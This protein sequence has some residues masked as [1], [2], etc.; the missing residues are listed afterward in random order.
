MNGND[1]AATA[2]RGGEELGA[3]SDGVS[4]AS[5]KMQIRKLKREITAL[6]SAMELA[7]SVSRT[8]A[9]FYSI[10]QAEKAR[11][12]QYLNM[13]LKNSLSIILL[14]N[15]EGRL[16]YCTDE[17]L[18]VAKIS[19]F[20][21][22]KG[23]L[24]SDIAAMNFGNAVSLA[25]V[26]KMFEEACH[27]MEVVHAEIA[28]PSEGRFAVYSVCITPMAGRDNYIGGFILLLHDVTDLAKAKERAELAS[29]AKSLFLARMSHEIRTPMNAIIGLGE[30]AYRECGQSKVLEHI[31]D[32]KN[33]G[34]NLLAIINDILDFS[35]IESG[36]ME[37]TLFP[38]E[39]SSLLSDVLAVIHIRMLEKPLKLITEISPTIPAVMTGDI[40]H[41]RQILFNLLGNAVKFTNQGFIKFLAYGNALTED[42]ILLTFVITDSGIGIR[43]EDVSRLFDDFIR[44]DEK[45]TSG[46]EGTGLGLTIAR[47]L[48]RA[49]G[50][51][52]DVTSEYGLGTTFTAT[53][54]QSVADWTPMGKIGVTNRRIET[55][56]AAF[57]APGAR[58]LVVDDFPSNL[59]VAEGLLALYRIKADTCLG[60]EEAI[61]RVG[62]R[63]YDLVF[64]DHMMPGM[65]GIET[66][67]AI[68][69]LG[70]RFTS[71]PIIALT[72]NAVSGM[73][74]MF[75]ENGFS[76]FL[77]KPIEM[78]KLDRML[79]KWVATE[80]CEEAPLGDESEVLSADVGAFP[81]IMGVDTADGISRIGGS[82]NRYLNL[83][84][85]FRRDA[86][87][88]FSLL[89]IPPDKA[90]LRVFTTL[91][92]SLK[93]AL[94]AIGAHALSQSAAL[95][96]K[97]CRKSEFSTIQEKL[98]P[99]RTEIHALASRIDE[100]LLRTH[101]G[102]EASGS[103]LETELLLLLKGALAEKSIDAMD[104]ALAKL[105]ALPLPGK[106]RKD[107]SRIAD[108]I[109]TADFEIAS[110]AVAELLRRGKHPPDVEASAPDP[111]R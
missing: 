108:L 75:L 56:R 62:K 60:G 17:F 41:I 36:R 48:C 31:A 71:L 109:L 43:R 92:H 52:V 18:R 88:G 89:E 53:I 101:S 19:G 34:A 26:A 8:H 110:E 70:S 105:Q 20:E 42:T 58:V 100:A 44:L 82:R 55:Q 14:L 85:T 50:G 21:S 11:Q 90:T 66:T 103:A 99:F 93:S 63:D 67:A 23:M 12:E 59:K 96:E 111:L 72:A 68:R 35:K 61:R 106:A 57:I 2:A 74:E 78:T 86:R 107:I 84:E 13:L 87:A 22:I 5:L 39:M 79:K 33:A 15:Q 1:F 54:V 65:D 76:D 80:K 51:D 77:P 97:A 30:L 29:T 94:A 37:F 45:N 24:F 3:E 49:M 104:G 46:V 64:M 83:L 16:A 28:L 32:I 10:L 98:A 81:E 7:D 27:D 91:V 4:S 47:S 38:Y 102:D 40:N 9:R 25:P 69:A 6:K 73:K 95:L